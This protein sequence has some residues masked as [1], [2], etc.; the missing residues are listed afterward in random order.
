MKRTILAG[1]ALAMLTTLIPIPAAD[2][3][4]SSGRNPWCC[5]MDHWDAAPGT[6]PITTTGNATIQAFTV[7]T[8]RACKT[9]TIAEAG[10]TQTHAE[11]RK[12]LGAGVAGNNPGRI[13]YGGWLRNRSATKQFA[14]P[15]HH[16]S[17]ASIVLN[18][19]GVSRCF[20]GHG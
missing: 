11:S 1:L 7:R 14:K 9:P 13:W 3:Q 8:A 5:A 12:A 18:C 19:E 16:R 2:A 4:V 15:E 17:P 10:R 20:Q 6:A